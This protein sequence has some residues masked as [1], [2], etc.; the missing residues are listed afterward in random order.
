MF[1]NIENLSTLINDYDV[2]LFD[3][4]GV[5]HEGEKLYQGVQ[6]L[7]NYLSERKIVR[8]ISNAPRL[9]TTT[10]KSLVEQ[11]L[12]IDDEHIFTSGE[13]ARLMLLE[14]E[15]YLQIKHPSIFHIGQDRNSE[16]LSGVSAKLVDTI[17]EA[18]IILL[19]AYKDYHENEDDITD[20][21]A[22]SLTKNLPILVANP[23]RAVIHSGKIRK[24]SGYFA[25]RY[26]SQGGK[27]IYA[28]KPNPIIY[29]ECFKSFDTSPEQKM[30]MIGDTFHTDIQGAKNMNIDSALVLTGNMG[31]MIDKTNIKNRIEAANYICAQQKIYPTRLVQV[32]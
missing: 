31:I 10:L 23:D 16:L 22:Y 15:Q 27:V 3:I 25:M 29:E 8:V 4:W 32:Q 21:L 17:D 13:I 5:L 20:H 30:L 26:E 2:F 14:S 18:N 9:K 12:K 7:Y 1:K 28:G 11:N 6:E 24:C 19:S